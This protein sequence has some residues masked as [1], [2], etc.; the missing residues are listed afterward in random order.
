MAKNV[1]SQKDFQKTQLPKTRKEQFFDI[2]KHRFGLILK[3]GFIL[4]LSFLPL[5]GAMIYKDSMIIIIN[6]NGYE[7]VRERLVTVYALYSLF[8]MVGLLIFF[9]VLAGIFKIV[10]ELIFGEPI[11][12]K[13]DFIE[14][15]KENWK[16]FSLISIFVS[17]FS[18]IDIIISFAYSNQIIIQISPTMVNFAIIF[19]LCFVSLFISSMYT[20]KVSTTI[21]GSII[22]YFTK[23]PLVLLGYI[24]TFGIFLIRHTP[25]LYVKYSLFLMLVF[26]LLPVALL[27]SFSI[28][29]HIFDENIN[30]NQYPDYYKKGLFINPDKR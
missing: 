19:P 16:S 30:K 27:M 23:F 17:I 26:I 25:L 1:V 8:I 5:L 29:I 13:E 3:I 21:K 12:F 7:D 24:F 18:V 20:N 28:H 11:F 22:I 14:G 6:S 2:L 15:I 4:L 10:K 9:I